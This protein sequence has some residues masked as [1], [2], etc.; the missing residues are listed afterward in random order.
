MNFSIFFFTKSGDVMF[1]ASEETT[2]GKPSGII[3]VPHVDIVNLTSEDEF[4]ILAC[5]GV[6]DVFEYQEAGSLLFP[7][8]CVFFSW[9]IEIF[10]FYLSDTI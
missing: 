9:S 8:F 2:S 1:K 3:A 4:L 5:D 7:S 10:F 6:W